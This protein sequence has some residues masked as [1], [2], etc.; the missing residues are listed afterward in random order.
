PTV[1]CLALSQ[2]WLL[3]KFFVMGRSR[4][5]PFWHFILAQGTEVFGSPSSNPLP[6]SLE[7]LEQIMS[8]SKL[9]ILVSC[10]GS[11]SATGWEE[12]H[13]QQDA[14]HAGFRP[15]GEWRRLG[16]PPVI[17][18]CGVTDH[19]EK[20]AALKVKAFL[21]G[22]SP[23]YS[24]GDLEGMT[25]IANMHVKVAR[26]LHS[27][28]LQYWL[29]EYLR[30]QPKGR[31]YRALILKFVKDRMGALL[32]VEVYTGEWDE[33]EKY[34]SGFTKVDEN[35]YSMKIFFEI[36]KQ[37]YLEALHRHDRAKAVDI[38][39]NDLKVFLTFNEEFYKEIKKL[40][41]LENFSVA[42]AVEP[43]LRCLLKADM[44]A[45]FCELV[46]QGETLQAIDH[47]INSAAKS[48][49][50][51]AGQ[52][53]VPIVLRGPNGAAAGVGA[54]HSQDLNVQITS[55]YNED[56]VFVTSCYIHL[57]QWTVESFN[58][59]L[60][61]FS[62]T[63]AL[64]PFTCLGIHGLL[65]GF[66]VVEPSKKGR[67][68]TKKRLKLQRKR[69]K[70]ERKEEN[71]NDQQSIRRKGKKIKQ[72]F[73]KAKA[74]LKYKI[75]KLIHLTIDQIGKLESDAQKEVTYYVLMQIQ[76]RMVSFEE[77]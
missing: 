55:F 57:H 45:I 72:K 43:K 16:C 32:L 24:A 71:K 62:L 22:D 50:M 34:L 73:L 3:D 61:L 37:K 48:N 30:R 5:R 63:N 56:S 69:I 67:Y 49:Y 15:P 38:I 29:L 10:L 20:V 27:N 9:E 36:T 59:Y 44:A 17:A 25:F 23:P 51:S 18:P 2:D 65:D 14:Q 4:T 1:A 53:S 11:K 46:A 64:A 52:I 74:R 12:V 68:L 31:K 41:T 13:V 26:R 47:I 39:V 19:A 28:S 58:P 70:N 54:Q 77:Q 66:E 7:K 42:A 76:S 35:R 8:L 6:K 21:R 40:L 60:E 33:V 75:E